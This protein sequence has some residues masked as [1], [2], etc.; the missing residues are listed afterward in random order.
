ML[1]RPVSVPPQPH[2]ETAMSLSIEGG[3]IVDAA[4]LPARASIA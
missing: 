1:G 3:Q 2:S 4:E